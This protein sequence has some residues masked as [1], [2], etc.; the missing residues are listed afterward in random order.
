MFLASLLDL[1]RGGEGSGRLQ[2]AAAGE[3]RCGRARLLSRVRDDLAS[4][5]EMAEE[6]TLEAE[7]VKRGT[8]CIAATYVRVGSR[9]DHAPEAVP[10][11]EGRGR[12]RGHDH[13]HDRGHDH[14]RDRGHD[15]DHGH[16]HGHDDGRGPSRNLP[17]I[18]VMLERSS[19][20]PY[21]KSLASSAFSLLASAEALT[22]GASSPDDVHFHE[23]GAV[24]SIVDTV[25]TVAAL[26][27][28]GVKTVSTSPLPMGKGRVWT[29]HG[30]LPVPAPATLRLMEGLEICTGPPSA[31]GELCTPTGV[32]LVRALVQALGRGLPEAGGLAVAGCGFGAGTKEFDHP[33]VLRAVLMEPPPSKKGRAPVT[34]S[35]R[36]P[37]V[38]RGGLRSSVADD[39]ASETEGAPTP[40][41][42]RPWNVSHVTELAANVD[43]VSP[44]I[45]GHV[46]QRLLLLPGCV[47]AWTCPIGMKKCRPAVQVRAMVAGNDADREENVD[48]AIETLMR[49]TTTLGVRVY[50][51]IE[52]ASL[53]RRFVTVPT[54]FEGGAG[55]GSVKVKLGMLKKTMGPNSEKEEE[56]E[57]ITVHPEFDDCQRVALAAG[58]PL[59]K[60][61]DVAKSVAEHK[62]RLVLDAKST[63]NDH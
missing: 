35:P 17:T 1:V 7:D 49:E 25:G 54:G 5:R 2:P 4:I 12:D 27:H 6:W 52:R 55:S 63:R 20:P 61:A 26:Y 23:V 13:G 30:I 58:V 21:V 47:D 28:L 42:P 53:H 45:L 48:A 33:N 34:A 9:W 50:R 51:D 43:D 46:V 18:V 15:H 32:A 57:V 40:S 11:A 3:P 41:R 44:E 39:V 22:H 24:D 56:E 37:V 36:P 60:V 29:E 8:G 14:G 16:D 10:G 38:S 62:L 31:A 19:L 59:R